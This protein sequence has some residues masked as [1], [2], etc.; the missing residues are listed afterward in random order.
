MLNKLVAT[1]RK[2]F[3]N[4]VSVWSFSF[5]DVHALHLHS[6]AVLVKVQHKDKKISD[7]SLQLNEWIS[8]ARSRQH[9]ILSTRRHPEESLELLGVV[10][11]S[12]PYDSRI[13][14]CRR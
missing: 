13:L 14:V 4:N 11:F 8:P 6:E 10:S 9:I 3:N 7:D 12:I 2:L 1:Y 5:P